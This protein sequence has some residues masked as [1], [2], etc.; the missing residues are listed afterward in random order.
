MIPDAHIYIIE[1]DETMVGLLKTL[2]EME[3]W[4]VST[5]RPTPGCTIPNLVD[6]IHPSLILMDINLRDLN[7]LEVLQEL[8]AEPL[9][10]NV[11]VIMSSGSDYKTLCLKYGADRFLLKPYMPDDLI[12]MIKEV[13]TENELK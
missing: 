9:T 3:G 5:Y 8:K 2:L 10:S 7:G 6:Q 13:L 4:R 11:R 12:E 1:D